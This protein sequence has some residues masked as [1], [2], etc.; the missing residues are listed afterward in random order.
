MVQESIG[1]LYFFLWST[2][3]IFAGK[4]CIMT[5][6]EQ[7]I[8]STVINGQQAKDELEKLKKKVT[9]TRDAMNQA[10][11][12]GNKALGDKLQKEL[13]QSQKEMNSFKIQ[14]RDVSETLEKLSDASISQLH[15]AAQTLN[16]QMKGLS[17]NTKEFAEKAEQLKSVKDRLRE[18]RVEGEKQQSLISKLF[19]N[20]NK[21]WGAVTQ[22]ISA[23]SGLSMSI[24]KVTQNYAD[25]EEAMADVQKYTGQTSEEVHEM[26][27]E[28]KKIDTRTTR[29]KLNALAGDA[30]RLG[31]TGKESIM[32]FVDAAEKI[33]VSLGDDLGDD[34][35]KNIGKIAQTFGEDKKKGLRGAMLATGSAVN[36]LS[37]SSSAAADY[38]V[39][40]TAR[41]AGVSTQADIAQTDIMG[42]ASVLDQNM[43]QEETSATA[44]SQL[45]SKMFQE[46][47]KFAKLAG[48]DVS[49]FTK[50][51]KTDANAALLDFLDAMGK[52]GGFDSL[53]PM[54]DEM[55]LSGTRCVGVLS[56]LATKL[57]DVKKA[58]AIASQA[59]TV[60]TSILDEYNVQN[61]TVQASVDKAKKEFLD[62]SIALGEQLLPI[63]KYTVSTGSMLVKVLSVLADFVTNHYRGLIA[64]TSAYIAYVAVAKA[65]WAITTSITKAKKAWGFVTAWLSLQHGQ[66]TKAL[67]LNRDAIVGCTVAEESL[68][69]AMIGTHGITKLLVA[70]SSLLKAAWYALTLQFGAARKAMTA[71]NV[72]VKMNPYGAL[73]TVIVAVVGAF[74]AWYASM[75][76][77]SEAAEKN[78]KRLKQLSEAQKQVM[79]VKQKANQALASEKTRL[80]ELNKI[81][82][83]NARKENERREAIAAIQKAVPEYHASI[84]KEGKLINDNT[85]AITKY[86]SKLNAAAMAQAAFDKLSELN[87]KKLDAQLKVKAKQT[88]VNAVNREIDRG[89]HTGEYK[90]ETRITMDDQ[91]KEYKVDND[92]LK[93]KKEELHLQEQALKNAKEEEQSLDRQIKAV[94][95]LINSNAEYKKAFEDINKGDGETPK[96]SSSSTTTKENGKDGDD[97]EKK[98]IEHS[99]AIAKEQLLINEAQYAQGEKLYADFLQRKQEITIEELERELS[100]YKKGTDEYNQV[101]AQLKSATAEQMKNV[102]KMEEEDI[103]AESEKIEESIKEAFIN[104]TDK[105]YQNQQ[106]LDE[107]LFQNTYQTLEKR[108]NLYAQTSQEWADLNKQMADLD[109]KHRLDKEKNFQ[110]K[111]NEFKKNFVG[112]GNSDLMK[113][114][115]EFAKELHTKLF[116]SKEEYLKAVE[117]IKKKYAEREEDK[118]I[119]GLSF[120]DSTF[121]SL[122]SAMDNLKGKMEEGKAS[123]QD[124]ASVAAT[125]INSV[126]ALMSALSA[127]TS[128]SYQAQIAAV[129]NRYDK[130]ISAAGKNKR[131]VAK[132]EE[133]KKKETNKLKEEQVEA[134]AKVSTAQVLINTAMSIAKGYAD[135]GPVL[136]SVLAALSVAMGTIQVATIQE[137]VKAQKSALQYYEGGFTG[138]K[139]Y[140][141]EAG[142]VHE[143]EFVANHN[144]VNNPNILPLLDMIDKAQKSNTSGSLTA[145]DIRSVTGTGG[146]AVVAPVVNVTTDNEEL[147]KAISL[148][149]EAVTDLNRILTEGIRAYSVI[150]GP[151]GSYQQTKRYERLIKAK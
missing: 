110:E 140:R 127:Y 42:F 142:V 147:N 138:G 9:E 22:I 68:K 57:D 135:Y 56:T 105:I 122:A 17:S 72:V 119:A 93:A 16:A 82:H 150:D 124:Y 118:T 21:N 15:K 19:D 111:V 115:L 139:Q 37:Q 146:T 123:W 121:A 28:F 29:E 67:I 95:T 48:K 66:F 11:A 27:E 96:S 53:A 131:K 76:K 148:T 58:Q 61:Q 50:M 99:K 106:A 85:D 104:P 77:T 149:S 2:D 1:L 32:E 83:D 60:G 3:T 89:T 54:F 75:N 87:A 38:L 103:I 39:S 31:I 63:V 44:L 25:M 6:E 136:G 145:E 62:L 36:E 113:L 134:E 47:Q 26:N 97:K 130:E 143:G 80:E 73:A 137:Q 43:Q 20:L 59:Y 71:F 12:A 90:Q 64:L 34:A 4:L 102:T 78:A 126:M 45:I 114:E 133:Q 112:K 98:A 107:A 33:D 74:A 86:I 151:D 125:A 8:V 144:T 117:K 79:D 35:V 94:N 108:R 132:L 128:A 141:K 10:Y 7:I 5:K 92:R 55:G 24:R 23:I 84:T 91:G 52:K 18:I 70:S 116:L 13:K 30:G 65:D 100:I 46:P 129:E 69:A 81:V 51:L 14:T 101:L 40:F 109:Y 49:E 41:L 88:K 120:N